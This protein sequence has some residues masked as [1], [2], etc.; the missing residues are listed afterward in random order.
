M[1]RISRTVKNLLN[2]KTTPEFLFSY[3][4]N[5]KNG[6][7]KKL[8]FETLNTEKDLMN[9]VPAGAQE[10]WLRRIQNVLDDPNNKDIPRSSNAGDIIG[11]HLHMHNGIKIDPLSYYSYP[12]LKML[13]DNKGVHEPQE[14]KIFQE[15]LKSLPPKNNRTMLELGAY[16]SFYSM[17]FKKV[18]SDANCFMVEPDRRNLMYG[19]RNLKLNN[20][21]GTFIHAGISNQ[22]NAS[23][24]TTTVDSICETHSID[25]LDILHSDIQGFEL[26]MLHGSKRML[27][28]NRV[29]Y[30]FIST[31]SNE[32]HRDCK[33]LLE[34]EYQF[35]LIASADLNE[36]YSWDGILVMKAPDYPGVSQVNIAKKI[37]ESV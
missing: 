1:V 18:F 4:F 32:L 29:G 15:V 9:K 34:T 10:H 12:M 20:Q 14:E 25:F 5:W 27:S 11:N 8:L 3:Y 24:N 7:D 31:H 16:W 33:A 22:E 28:E 36:S 6:K 2:S 13:M 21:A 37:N 23:K 30:V 26:K 35:D 19:K 17:W